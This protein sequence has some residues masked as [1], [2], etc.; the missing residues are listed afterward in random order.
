MTMATSLPSPDLSLSDTA[1]QPDE[2][3]TVPK[4]SAA[5][6]Q[7]NDMKS[8]LSDDSDGSQMGTPD[9]GEYDKIEKTTIDPRTKISSLLK[10]KEKEWT[11]VVENR[12]G[13]LRLLDLP[14]DVLKEI[15]KEVRAPLSRCRHM[16]TIPSFQVTHT[17]DLTALALTHSALHNLAIPH[18]YS[19]FDIVWPDAHATTD[20]R[21]GVDA[22]TYG[23]A[24]LCM[25]DVF[26]DYSLGQSFTCL[27]C[28]TQNIVECNH[29]LKSGQRS[30]QRRLGNQYPQFTRKFSLGNGPADWVQEY[31]ITKESGKMLGTLVALAVARMVNL[32][33][34]VWDMPTGVLR[35]VWLAL[36]SLQNRHPEHECRL[37]RVWVR[38]HDNSDPANLPPAQSSTTAASTTPQMLAGSTMTSVGWTIPTSSASNTQG[39]PQPLSYAQ[40]RV[41]YPT[42]SV[43]PPLR[44]LS[45]LDIDE[46]DYLDEM[47]VLIA[48]SKDR[49]RELRVGISAKAV[50]RDFVIAW[51]GLELHQV[52]HKAQ[53]PGAS[54]I[55]ERRL[56][57]VLGVLLGRVFDIRKKQKAKL[58]GKDWNTTASSPLASQPLPTQTPLALVPGTQSSDVLLNHIP[59]TAEN[60]SSEEDWAGKDTAPLNEAVL[61]APGTTLNINSGPPT[62]STGGLNLNPQPNITPTGVESAQSDVESLNALITAHDLI[63]PSAEESHDVSQPDIAAE[64]PLRRSPAHN[65]RQSHFSEAQS[66]ERERLDGKLRLQTL[67]LERVPLSVTVL[68]KAF[69]WSVLTNL[70][71]LDCSQHDRLWVMLRRHF[72]P[73]PLGPPSSTKHAASVSLQYHLNLKKIHTD[74]ASLAL[75]AFLRET[76]APNTLETLFLQD[77]KRSSTTSVTIV[78]TL[79]AST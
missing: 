38:W 21:T 30:G 24:T 5:Y 9:S 74:A 59:E 62:N 65:Q 19:R 39:N 20:P 63:S 18:I 50:N 4:T 45:V 48:K 44:S 61:S 26:T 35:D 1:S 70:T 15:V 73:S 56:G 52:D 51:D 64:P 60:S 66:V 53:W 77:R 43:L 2:L 54:T 6:Q 37:E 55:G 10:D 8:A 16:L 76:L 57:G 12:K 47:S 14:M 69:D 36:S 41:E 75:I 25:G 13:P 67:E 68:Q 79:P 71:I 3:P 32:E 31:L 11:A 46:L 34:F 23:L 58:E 17:N 72:Q 22:L 28:G 33:T 78:S 27:N 42:L 29:G 7:S 40:S 49:L